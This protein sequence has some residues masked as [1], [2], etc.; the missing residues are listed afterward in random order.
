[1]NLIAFV[2]F[3]GSGKNTAAQPLVD[4]G[5]HALSF[6]DAIKDSLAAIFCWPRHMLEGD[7]AESRV[8]RETVDQWWASK[9]SIPDFSPRR[10]MQLV[11]TEAMRQHF[12]PEVWILNVERRIALLP[13]GSKVVLIDGRFPN[14]LDMARRLGG[15]VARI[16]KGA[17][18]EWFDAAAT[19][20]ECSPYGGFEQRHVDALSRM[21]EAGVHKSEWAWVGYP[22]DRTFAND[23]TI[24][25][26]HAAVRAAYLAR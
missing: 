26:L 25:D 10:A 14:E 4:A 23:G 6:A 9:L 11:G 12:H 18:P 2:G 17:E 16:K 15:T 22:M 3:K 8:W 1:M 19:V 24:D 7:T 5:Y 13:L 21:T 20:N